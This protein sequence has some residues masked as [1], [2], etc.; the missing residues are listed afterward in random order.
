MRGEVCDRRQRQRQRVAVFVR[1]IILTRG[2]IRGFQLV[3]ARW[4]YAVPFSAWNADG[5]VA[6]PAD[7]SRVPE[8]SKGAAASAETMVQE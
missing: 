1:R 7:A 8:A 4:P 5:K 3:G 6:P 2:V